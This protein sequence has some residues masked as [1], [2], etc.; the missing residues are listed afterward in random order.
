MTNKLLKKIKSCNREALS[1]K[2]QLSQQR[3]ETFFDLSNDQFVKI[4][5]EN[6]QNNVLSFK[7]L[8]IKSK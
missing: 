2:K 3:Y 6:I 1:H 5:L 7:Y 8:E 4:T